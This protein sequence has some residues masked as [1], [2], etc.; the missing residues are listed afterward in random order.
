MSTASWDVPYSQLT[1]EEKSSRLVYRWAWYVGTTPCIGQLQH[2]NHNQGLSWRTVVRGNPFRGQNLH[3]VAHCVWSEKWLKVWIRINSSAVANGLIGW[4]LQRNRTGKMVT[5]KAVKEPRDGPPWRAYIPASSGTCFALSRSYFTAHHGACACVYLVVLCSSHLYR[6]GSPGWP[7]SLG[8]ACSWPLHTPDLQLPSSF[9]MS[10]H[11]PQLACALGCRFLLHVHNWTLTPL[12]HPTPSLG[13]PVLYR[14]VSRTVNALRF[15]SAHE[16][17]CR[18][19]EML[20]ED[21][22]FVGQRLLMAKLVARSFMFMLV[23]RCPHFVPLS[24]HDDADEPRWRCAHAMSC[25]TV[26]NTELR[27]LWIS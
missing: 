22:R 17:K 13:P 5:R 16:L 15:Y 10:T 6:E 4:Q 2:F 20:A 12:V 24:L 8:W 18:T 23:S 26:G 19:L 3:L 14:I 9:C 27:D 11:W 21:M 7:C 1:M 25:A